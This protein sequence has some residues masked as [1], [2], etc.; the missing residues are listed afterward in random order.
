MSFL[1]GFDETWT[2][3][4]DYVLGTTREIWDERRMDRLARYYAEDVVQRTPLALREGRR[5][6]AAAVQGALAEFPDGEMLGEDVIWSQTGYKS[7]YS[8]HRTLTTGRHAGAGL[9]GAASGKPVTFRTMTDSWCRGNAVAEQWVVR[10]QSAIL[11]QLGLD[12]ADWTRDLIAREGGPE[13]CTRP[14]SAATDLP[15]RY[16]GLGNDNAWGQ[17]LAGL[18]G[19][20]MAGEVAAIVDSYD[21]AA[22]L[23]YPGQDT[24]AGWPEAERFWMA[25]RAAFPS[26][27]FGVR[28]AVGMEEP[29]CPPRAAVRWELAGRHDGW[30]QFGAPTG[31]EVFVMGITHAEFGP[32]GLRR[33]WTLFDETAVWKQILLATGKV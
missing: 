18:L 9:F 22:E 12:A 21:R 17:H 2:D 29:L 16:E 23:A 5:A 33:D 8:S 24:G 6:V 4:S 11:R 15:A 14:L 19:R 25:L 3:A 20:I 31:A 26:A 10:D 13:A 27:R 30:G 7:F 32:R 28:H 1:P